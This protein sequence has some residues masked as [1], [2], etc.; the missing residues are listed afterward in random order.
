MPRKRMLSDADILYNCLLSTG[1]H[2]EPQSSSW[3]PK[4]LNNKTPVA[5]MS[6]FLIIPKNVQQFMEDHF[7]HKIVH[8]LFSG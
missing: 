8:K 5:V 3:H 6:A 4:G 7:S 1:H 2:S